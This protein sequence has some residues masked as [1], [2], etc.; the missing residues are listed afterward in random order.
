MLSI[1]EKNNIRLAMVRRYNNGAF[2]H[3]YIFGFVRGGLVYAVQVNNAADLLNSLTYVE[4]RSSG[5]NLRY[6]PNKAQQEI[7]LANA[8]RVEILGSVDWLES[9]KANHHNNRGDVFEYY[10]CKRWNGTQPANR[11]E[12]FTTCGDFWT[13]DGVHF[14]CK[15][16]ASTGA[17]TFTDEK[18]LANLGL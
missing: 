14:Q 4:K 7:I 6:R 12:K 18:T 1:E 11:S 17:A 5:Y 8:A 13:A 16:G 9:E 2:T 10:A 3:N 15:F